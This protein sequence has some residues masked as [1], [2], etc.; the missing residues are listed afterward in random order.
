MV[1]DE[2]HASLGRNRFDKERVKALVFELLE[3]VGEDPSRSGLAQ[4]PTRVAEMLEELLSG[5][6]QDGGSFLG[7]VFPAGHEEM[8]ILREITFFSLCEHHVLPFF[9]EVHVAY[10]PNESGYIAG[11]SGIARL[12]DGLSRK[13]QVQERLTTEIANA[14]HDSMKP[15]GVLVVVEAEHLCMSMRGSKKVGS[16]AMT[17][18]VR[19]AFKRDGVTRAEALELISKGRNA[20]H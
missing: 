6:H 4:T 5:T 13:L 7:S 19:G 8:V 20:V 10:I 15:K 16:R 11:L 9:G 2:S 18:A 1:P 12:V 17:S 3:A 14:I